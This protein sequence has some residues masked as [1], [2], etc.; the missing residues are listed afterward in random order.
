MSSCQSIMGR[1]A[2][3]NSKLKRLFR[4][5]LGVLIL[6]NS[7]VFATELAPVGEHQYLSVDM[8]VGQQE[9]EKRNYIRYGIKDLKK[10]VVIDKTGTDIQSLINISR[11]GV[12]IKTKTPTSIGQII[13]IKLVYED[14]AINTE[15]QIVFTDGDIAGA[16]FV[17]I[18][19]Q[20]ENNLL[21]LSIRLDADNGHLVTKLSS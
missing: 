14:I 3:I 6:G 19:K 1:K 16:K 17:N 18:N 4:V 8:I 20:T 10:P 9:N 11:G 21:Y 7:F 5:L 2:L 15:A 12:A 13:P